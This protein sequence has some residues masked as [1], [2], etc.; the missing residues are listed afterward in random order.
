MTEL[1]ADTE[2]GH[3]AAH[4]VDVPDHMTPTPQAIAQQYYH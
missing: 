4:R 1:Q 3:S 2:P